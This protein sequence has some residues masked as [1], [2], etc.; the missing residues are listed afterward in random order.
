MKANIIKNKCRYFAIILTIKISIFL[1]FVVI[2]PFILSFIRGDRPF[3]RTFLPQLT[4]FILLLTLFLNR[5]FEILIKNLTFSKEIA[6]LLGI[7]LYSESTFFLEI[8]RISNVLKD[9]IPHGIRL[10]NI[11]YNFYHFH[12]HPGK[13]LKLYKQKIETEY[14]PLFIYGVDGSIILLYREAM[15]VSAYNIRVMRYYLEHRFKDQTGVYIL[16]PRPVSAIKKIASSF[17]SEPV[18]VNEELQYHNLY[19]VDL[20]NYRENKT[21]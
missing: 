20:H 1:I 14:H 15:E 2:G 12:Y 3:M 16:S 7:F 17:N 13:I 10:Q 21:R 6:L 18:R 5:T 9:S 4:F 19:F 11:Y 8:H